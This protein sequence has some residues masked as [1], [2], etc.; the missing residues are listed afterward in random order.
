MA[1]G[2]VISYGE[3]DVDQREDCWWIK[4]GINPSVT[5]TSANISYGHH[6][7]VDEC[8]DAACSSNVTSLDDLHDIDSETAANCVACDA[9]SDSRSG[10]VECTVS[11]AGMYSLTWAGK[12]IA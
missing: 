9:G 11:D 4:G 6:V 10:E 3:V 7:Y 1:P 2:G 12:C 8:G 5:F